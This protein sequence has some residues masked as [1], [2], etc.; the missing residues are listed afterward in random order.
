MDQSQSV[1]RPT[2]PEHGASI[3][4]VLGPVVERVR[5]A[6]DLDPYLSLRALAGYAGLSVRTLRTHLAD[7]LRPL[8]CYRVGGKVLVRRSD[9]DTWMLHF[10]R[11]QAPAMERVMR[12]VMPAPRSARRR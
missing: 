1:A 6:T 12:E 11:T 2:T 3:G 8:P 5:L 10:R 9:F 7:P 4:R